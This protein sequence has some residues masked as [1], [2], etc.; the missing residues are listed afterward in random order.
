[1]LSWLKLLI[2]LTIIGAVAFLAQGAAIA[3]GPSAGDQQYI[4]PLGGSNSSS[5]SH[6]ASHSS[7]SSSSS[8]TSSQAPTPAPP[9]TTTPTVTA[10]SATA[11]PSASTASTT[12]TATTASSPTAGDPSKTLPFTGFDASLGAAIGLSMLASGLYLRRVS[13]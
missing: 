9:T 4:D 11:T 3:S 8:S 7:H 1:M 5:G 13:R 6:H 12:P 10:P 2:L